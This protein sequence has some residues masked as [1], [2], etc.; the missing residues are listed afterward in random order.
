MEIDK[1]F[2]KKKLDVRIIMFPFV[3]SEDQLTKVLTKAVSNSVFSNS[4]DKLRGNVASYI[5][6]KL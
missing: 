6:V 3:G 5:L 1:H 4:L 2:I